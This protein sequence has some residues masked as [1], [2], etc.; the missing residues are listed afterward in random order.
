[1]APKPSF[2]FRFWPTVGTLVGL[3]IVVSLGTWQL[4]RYLAKL[5]IEAERDARLE[6][7]P[8]RIDDLTDVDP[9]ALNYRRV[10]ATGRLDPAYTF[11]FKHRTHEKRPGVW[12][13][14]VLRLGDGGALLV[15]RGW[16]HVEHAEALAA[17]PP[18][19][20]AQT[21]EGLFHVP[22][23]IIADEAMRQR[24]EAGEAGL[25]DEPT[26]W[27]SVD[28]TAIYD[29]LPYETPDQ[30]AV[31][32]LGPAHSGEPY[33]IAGYDTVAEPY[34]TS[35]RH[36]GYVVTWYGLALALV[37]MYLAYGFGY[38]GSFGRRSPSND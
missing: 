9:D 24:L 28:L 2:H 8:A 25:T 20:D 12:L 4:T 11:I 16:V 27:D 33:P 13:G 26:A 21:F 1:M 36:M 37:G 10:R 35:D 7:P 19:G 23:R 30:P 17:T 15:N 34:L 22:P 6:K 18:R 5:E 14:G 38:L 3:A 31:V 32:M 29:A